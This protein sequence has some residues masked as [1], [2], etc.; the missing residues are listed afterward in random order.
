[1]EEGKEGERGRGI[2]KR[3]EGEEGKELK[4]GRQRQRG[5]RPLFILLV[6]RRKGGL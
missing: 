4:R 2:G 1:M 5:W 6:G 3:E